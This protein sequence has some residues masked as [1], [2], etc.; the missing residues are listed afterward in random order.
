MIIN[1]TALNMKI[2][3]YLTITLLA[4]IS[5]QGCANKIAKS[6]YLDYQTKANLI[7]PLRGESLVVH[8]GR[9]IEQNGHASEK[10]QRFAVDVVALKQGSRTLKQQGITVF[11][12]VTY[13]GNSKLNESYY[14]YGREVVAPASGKVVDTL[15]GVPDA[16]PSESHQ[17]FKQPAGNYVVIDHGNNEFSMLAHL[18]NGSTV[19]NKGDL[20]VAGDI[21]GF[22][23]NT[24]NSTEPHLHY[25][26]QNTS[27]WKNGEGLP[28]Q[29]QQYI[30]NGQFIQRGEPIRGQIIESN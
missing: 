5:L 22:V 3:K 18:K 20:V 19:F 12:V 16:I 7:F 9:N 17:D 6:N 25:H 14:I 21:I 23:G 10:D 11:D 4:I 26:L 1:H 15:D 8:G 27:K 30:A 13:E 29:F 28:A 24:G 2:L